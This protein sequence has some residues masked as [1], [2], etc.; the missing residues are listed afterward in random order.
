MNETQQISC[1]RIER[2]IAEMTKTPN[3]ENLV[4]ILESIRLGICEDCSLLVPVELP[5]TAGQNE[6]AAENSVEAAETKDALQFAM[7]KLQ[8][9][10]G[11]Q[12]LVAFTSQA[13]AE[14]GQPSP[15]AAT[16]AGAFLKAVMEMDDIS[17]IILNPWGDLFFLLDKEL[18]ELIRGAGEPQNHIFIE[19][20]D[21]TELDCECI[22]NAANKTLL[23]GGGVDGAI[24]RAAGPGLLAECRKL[25]GCETGEAKLTGGYN[26]KAK[27]VIHT[28]GPVYS[29]TEK[30]KKLLTACYWNSL[31]L[32]KAHGIHSIAF[33]AIST[34]V[35]AYP[36]EEAVPVA[37]LTVSHWLDVNHGYGMDVVMSCF[38]QR[39]YDMYEKFIAACHSEADG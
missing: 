14:K 12:T 39:A 26:L 7:R 3:E 29:G 19:K 28:V 31:E 4:A 10:D 11:R 18:I 6:T 35:Y 8:L 5:E 2:A 9:K 22:V 1:E 25:G 23:G 24:H 33:P 37:M 13:E 32:A 38:D 30:D 34:G 16:K 21:I 36:L 27:H 17:G 20:G 15:V